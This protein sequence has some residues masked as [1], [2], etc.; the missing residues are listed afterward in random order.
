MALCPPASPANGDIDVSC[1]TQQMA[2]QMLLCPIYFCGY[3]E[4][5]LA[6]NGEHG[7]EHCK[8]TPDWTVDPPV[9][10]FNFSI[11]QEEIAICSNK[12]TVPLA[13]MPITHTLNSDQ[14]KSFM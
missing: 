6:L 1:G 8:G 9:L 11:T 13:S 5:L 7:K 4:S 10:R 2:L 3:N 12:L 14:G